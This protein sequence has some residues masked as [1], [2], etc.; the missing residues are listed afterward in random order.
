MLTIVV[1]GRVSRCRLIG[2]ISPL[3]ACLPASGSARQAAPAE[4]FDSASYVGRCMPVVASDH[5]RRS[6]PTK[7]EFT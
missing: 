4:V 3:L 2:M 6:R 1:P 5:V 7:R